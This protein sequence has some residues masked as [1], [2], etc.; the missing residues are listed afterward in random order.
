MS[1]KINVRVE[2]TKA[3]KLKS[4]GNKLYRII[5]VLAAIVWALYFLGFI[6]NV[7][8]PDKFDMGFAMLMSCFYFSY[9]AKK[10]W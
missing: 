9:L 2:K 5:C 1:Q 8:T 6:L 7:Y 3:E 4:M 10:G